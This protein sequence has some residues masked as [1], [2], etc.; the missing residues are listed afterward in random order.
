MRIFLA[1]LACVFGATTSAHAERT[2]HAVVVEKSAFAAAA[3]EVSNIIFLNRCV[4]NCTITKGA[5]DAR[6]NTSSIPVGAAGAT[7]TLSAFNKGDAAW[8]E[9]VTCVRDL[10]LPYGV[11]ITDVD[12]GPN[13][14]HHEAMV[15]GTDAEIGWDGALGVGSVDPD[16]AP[17]NNGI[18]YAFANAHADIEDLC[19]TV[20][21]EVGH[22]YG[23][24]HVFDCH[25]PM[26][27]LPG[28]FRK[29]FRNEDYICGEYEERACRCGNVQN[30]HTRLF[31]L[32]GKGNDIPAPDVEIIGPMAGATINASTVIEGTLTAGRGLGTIELWI[33]GHKWDEQQG[34]ALDRQTGTFGFNLPSEL[35]N[36]VLDIEV[37]ANTDLGE[38]FAPGLAS[39]T[40]TLGAACT[41][42]DACLD[43]Q[44]CTDGRCLWGDATGELG[45]ACDFDQFCLSGRCEGTC[46]ES[47][48][49][50]IAGDCPNGFI[51]D[52][53]GGGLC[54]P[55]SDD[56]GGGGCCQAS[57]SL[58]AGLAQA[59]AALAMMLLL[60]ARR[61]S[62]A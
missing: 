55:G 46:T 9:L 39:V 47:C 60:V 10:Y 17:Y 34:P 8:S 4:G 12:P 45:D 5:T 62:A 6:T 1:V 59:M 50:G 41:N 57:G 27:Y 11:Q 29:Y 2:T 23:L 25:D 35:P 14:L 56:E 52:P 44:Q 36:S 3:G 26:T 49:V 54:F 37:R 24:D 20:A 18:S 58:G 21:Q 48:V 42:A 38:P 43:G 33:N 53:V 22:T 31:T 7:Y 28:C 61:R 30:S 15:A 16:C 40:V 13:V 51:C 32:F 19:W